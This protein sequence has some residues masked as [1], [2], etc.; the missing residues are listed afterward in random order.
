MSDSTVNPPPQMTPI[1]SPDPLEELRRN[2]PPRP[3]SFP[4]GSLWVHHGN[5]HQ[6]IVTGWT[7]DTSPAED[8]WKV[9][10]RR[11]EDR[12]NDFPFSRS[13]E[14]WETRFTRIG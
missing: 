7:Y 14:S 1:G 10:F 12:N 5:N 9:Q 13:L 4:V 2:I 3:T 11:I 6:Y 8:R